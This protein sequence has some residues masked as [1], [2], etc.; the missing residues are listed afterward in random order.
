[1]Y[2]IVISVRLGGIAELLLLRHRGPEHTPRMRCSLKAYCATLFRTYVLDIS[3]FRRQMPLRPHDVRDP[4]S[5]M[6][7]LMG[8]N[9]NQ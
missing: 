8:K 7:N 1:M 9:S 3:N 2:K 5:E 6:W 4:C